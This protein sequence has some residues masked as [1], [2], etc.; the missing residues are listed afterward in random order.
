[1]T[2]NNFSNKGDLHE[3]PTAQ[4]RKE[5]HIELAFEAIVENDMLDQR[6]NYE[7]MLSSHPSDT[8]SLL[9]TEF[10]GFQMNA[11]LWVSSMTGGTERANRIN[12]NL[13][14]ACGEFGFGMGLGSCRSLLRSDERLE[15]FNVKHLMMDQ[16]LFANLGIAQ[17]ESLIASDEIHLIDALIAKLK[18]DGLI[19]HVNP[20][21][22]WLQP[23]GD[24]IKKAPIETIA[25]L[26]ASASYPIIVKEVGQG[27]GPQSL[28]ELMKMPLAAI[29]F[30]AHG[31]TNFAMLEM[32]RHDHAIIN[33]YRGLASIG[34]SAIDM[35]HMVNAIL[36]SNIKDI[37]CSTFI[38]SG[39]VKGF[40]DGHFL[41]ESLQ[42]SSVVYG[43]AS[44]FLKHALGA[45]EDLANHIKRQIDGLALAKTFLK[46]K[47]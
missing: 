31:G 21:Q 43:Q 7:P 25:Q 5:D 14:R 8:L 9:K 39:G 45:Y 16:P 38:I 20:M 34:H 2:K 23:E 33:N 30:A 24:V 11:P 26:L 47:V 6:F 19:V 40:L 18:A 13:A 37:Q 46:V 10:L 4:Q 44:G 29:D 22:E 28:L 27:M 12:H 35:V 3:D 36:Q 1:M 41:L 32:M 42:A 15:D 17:V